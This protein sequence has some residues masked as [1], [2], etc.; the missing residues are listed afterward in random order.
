M[1]SIKG[2]R[3]H[4]LAANEASK[5]NFKDQ[6]KGKGK[7]P[8]ARKER[9]SK[10]ADEYSSYHKGKNKK[11]RSKCWY[12]QKIYHLEYSCMRK[13]IDEMENML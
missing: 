8:E 3:D 11:E 9:F 7:N 5:P 4:S 6:K 2:S 1:G 12:C 10:P 13:T